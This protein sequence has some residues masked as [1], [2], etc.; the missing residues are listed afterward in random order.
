MTLSSLTRGLKTLA[1]LT[2]VG[3]VAACSSD[4]GTTPN[5]DDE[6]VIGGLVV[7]SDGFNL[8]SVFAGEVSGTLRVADGQT[9]PIWNVVFVDDD[10]VEFEVFDNEEMEATLADNSFVEYVQEGDF[11]FRLIGT[12]QG[13]TTIVFRYLQDGS[14][15]YTSPAIPLEVFGP[16]E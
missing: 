14:S 4:S 7:E 9:G 3:A 1:T 12:D 11:S 13:Q 16:T 15:I 8:A 2:L 10:G 6:L 5:D